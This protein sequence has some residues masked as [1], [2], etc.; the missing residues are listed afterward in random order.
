MSQEH[1]FVVKIMTPA[2][3]SSTISKQNVRVQIMM[4]FI[5]CEVLFSLLCVCLGGGR[6][7]FRYIF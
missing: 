7:G 1:V 5:V 4:H 2:P 3:S 6:M